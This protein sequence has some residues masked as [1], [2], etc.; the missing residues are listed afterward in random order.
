LIV[1]DLNFG[2]QMTLD[3]TLQNRNGHTS[4]DI[5]HPSLPTKPRAGAHRP[6]G[7]K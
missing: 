1:S 5:H 7:A 4:G 2:M 3:I 6:Y